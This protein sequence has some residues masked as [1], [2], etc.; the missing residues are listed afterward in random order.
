M[1]HQ[2]TL[3]DFFSRKRWPLYLSCVIIMVSLAITAV[4]NIINS[5]VWWGRIDRDL[6]LIG[7]V[8]SLVVT[9]V[10]SPVAIYLIRKYIDLEKMNRSLQAEIDLEKG[11]RELEERLHRAEK[12]EALGTLAGGVAHD[13]NNIFGVLVGYSELLGRK[14]PKESPLGSYADNILRSGLRGAAIVQDLLTLT[15]RGVAVLEVVD[16]N[17]IVSDYLRT[18]EYEKLKSEHREVK[19]SIDLAEG[20]LKIKG[21]PIHLSKMIANLVFNAAEAIPGH[22]E[23]TIRTEDRYLDLPLRGYDDVKEGDYSVLTVSDTGNGIAAKDVPKIF[24]PFYTNKVMGRSGTGL[25]LAVVW[26]TVKDHRGYIDVRSE[27]GKESTFAIYIPITREEIVE[28]GK[29]VDSELYRGKGEAILVVDDVK[30]QRELAVSM[31]QSLGYD[32][33]AVASGE[34][35]IHYLGGKRTDLMVLDM[36]MAPGID[37]LETY[38]RVLEVNPKQRAIIVSGFSETERVRTALKLGA[39]AYVRKPYVI[40][41]IGMAIR[42]EL[43]R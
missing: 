6:I 22:G 16:L 38:E 34:E 18:P 35:A 2:Q 1:N 10:V 26:G 4:M 40:E 19:V 23:I 20:L 5:L 21:S 9:I 8:D 33:A 28:R 12:M 17:R 24:E 30:E 27:D 31:L 29:V 37:G 13:L 3:V 15:R 25:G 41:K 43:D 36:V 39:G 42:K 32:A 11:H 7:C 14:F